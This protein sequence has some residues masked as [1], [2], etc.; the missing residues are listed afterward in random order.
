[1]ICI[2]LSYGNYLN[3]I[4]LRIETPERETLSQPRRCQ[5]QAEL[6]G[7]PASESRMRGSETNEMHGEVELVGVRVGRLDYWLQ[8]RVPMQQAIRFVFCL[9]STTS[10]VFVVV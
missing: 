6:I 4:L 1:M 2:S 7:V 3:I 9:N 8:L 10:S 5:E